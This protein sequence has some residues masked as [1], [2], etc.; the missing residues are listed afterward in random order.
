M[1]EQIITIQGVKYALLPLKILEQLRG[2]LEEFQ[3]IA[4]V[5]E[6]KERISRGEG[7]Y[8]PAYILDEILDNGKNPVKV[9]REYR[10]MT[11]EQL[12]EKAGISVHMVRKIENGES[13]GSIS[14]IKAIAKALNLDI[15]ML[16]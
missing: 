13:E 3:D 12:A 9:Y 11:Q 6:I 15:D 1:T 2:K 7:E 5:M 10:K 14:T 16:V 8:F 4:D